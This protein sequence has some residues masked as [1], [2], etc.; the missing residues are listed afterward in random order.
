MPH[1]DV[2]VRP[3]SRRKEVRRRMP[4][5]GADAAYEWQKKKQQMGLFEVSM[6]LH[7]QFFVANVL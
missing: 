3:T 1:P 6:F 2:F 4:S 7:D 5:Q